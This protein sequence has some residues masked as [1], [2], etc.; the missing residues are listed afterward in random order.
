MANKQW[1]QLVCTCAAI[2]VATV[3]SAQTAPDVT[4]HN[5]FPN[6]YEFGNWAKMP[7]GRK[8][9]STSA[10]SIDRD[11]TSVWVAARCGAD[12]AGSRQNCL[13]NATVDPITKFD[14]SGKMVKSFGAGLGDGLPGQCADSWRR[15]RTRPQ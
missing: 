15:G 4:D 12:G 6:P 5:A 2:G 10:V 14:S 8:L 11:G 3:A 9:G 1:K 7:E 13:T